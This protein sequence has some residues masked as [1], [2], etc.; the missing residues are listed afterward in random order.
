ML[1]LELNLHIVFF[2]SLCHCIIHTLIKINLSYIEM[3]IGILAYLSKNTGFF[4]SFFDTTVSIISYT[5]ILSTNNLIVTKY[6]V[7]RFRYFFHTPPISVLLS[8]W[9]VSDAY[10]CSIIYIYIYQVYKHHRCTYLLDFLFNSIQVL[11][12]S[13]PIIF[14]N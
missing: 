1:V 10:I 2:L 3:A 12:I 11:T 5:Y 14:L 9:V 4:I 7:L 6:F 13:I 8:H